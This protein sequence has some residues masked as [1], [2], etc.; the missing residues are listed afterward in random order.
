MVCLIRDAL[1]DCDLTRI[2]KDSRVRLRFRSTRYSSDNST[3]TDAY[4]V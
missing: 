1:D 2:D 3:D 4:E